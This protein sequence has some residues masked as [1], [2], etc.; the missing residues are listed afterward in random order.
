V[1]NGTEKCHEYEL[2]RPAATG[3]QPSSAAVAPRCPFSVVVIKL[4][5]V[6]LSYLFTNVSV[7]VATFRVVTTNE[8]RLVITWV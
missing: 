7:M 5:Y 8:P 3:R 4:A 1:N 2:P 6:A